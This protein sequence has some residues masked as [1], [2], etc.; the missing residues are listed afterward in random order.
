MKE[1]IV[2]ALEKIAA[3]TKSNA[4]IIPDKVTLDQWVAIGRKLY[5]TGQ[6]MT[7]W[8]ADWA[9]YGEREYGKLKEFCEGNGLNYGTI[10]NLASVALAVELSRR[11]DNLSFS[12][13]VE[14]SA[15]PAREQSKW[16]SQAAKDNWSVVELRRRIRES[17][18]IHAPEKTYG[19]SDEGIQMSKIFLDASVILERKSEFVKENSDEVWNYA[20]P[21]LKKA[22]ALW[23]EKVQVK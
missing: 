17:T 1:E 16:L 14:V 12:H 23:P 4:L 3:K 6:T 22:A 21:F 20:S 9:A 18:M 8:L 13:H 19:P 10:R 11:R 2:S 7:W 5:H 15:L